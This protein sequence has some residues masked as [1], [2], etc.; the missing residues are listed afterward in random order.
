MRKRVLSGRCFIGAQKTLALFLICLFVF[1]DI[2]TFLDWPLLFE[3]EAAQATIDAT[4]STAQLEHV[5]IGSQTVFVSDQVGYKF[6]VD[7]TG[8]CVYSK[9]TNG[10]TSWGAAVTVDAVTTCFGVAVWYDRWTPGDNGNYIHIL[11]MD[12]GAGADELWYNRLDT[13]SDTR[14]LGQTPTS[15]VSNSGQVPTY[16]AG[17]NTGSIT[18][19]TDGTLYMA[20]AD[21]SDSFVVECSS[22]CGVATSWTETGTNPMDLAAD[23]SLVL[24]LSGGDI[25]LINRDISA[26]DMRSKVWNNAGSSWSASWSTI[27]ANALENSVYDPAF[28]A[29]VNK[30]TGDVFLAYVDDST[31]GTIGGNNDSIK[32]ALY[33]GGSWSSK[34][35]VETNSSL[36]LTDVSLAIDAN[37]GNVYVS[38]TGRTTPAT[39]TTA[40]V[41]W[42]TSTS[43]MTSWSSRQG[44][45]NTGADDI[46]GLG[47]NGYSDERMYVTWYGLTP[48][49]IFGNTLA[50]ITPITVVSASGTQISTVR[51][52]TTNFY[53]G[54]KFL[55]KENV[56]SRNVTDIT[57]AE[58]G[59]VDAAN[60]LTNITLRYDLDTTAPYDCAS[61]SYAGSES[62]FGSTDTNGFSG[63]DGSSSFTGSVGISPTQAMCVYV[64]M[65]VLKA[66][67]DTST[68]DI[69][70]TNPVT[71]VLLSGGVS[72][73]PATVQ[74][75]GGSTTIVDSNLTQTHYHWRNDNGN[76]TTATSRTA[77]VQD[78][79][80]NSLQQSVPVRLRFGV[81]NEGSTTS[82]PTTFRLEYANNPS[83][84]DLATGWTDVGAADDDWNMYDSSFVTHAANTTDISVGIGGV[85]N[86]NTDLLTPNGGQRDTSSQSGS[87]TFL[88][89]NWTELEFSI[90]ASTTAA[91]G[92]NYCFRLTNAGDPLPTYTNYARG[93]IQ[94]DVTVRAT[95]TQVA[96]VDIPTS[97]FYIG[98]TFS[99]TENTSS[100]NVTVITI[101]ESGSVDAT[102]GLDGVRLYY[103]LDTTAPYNCVSETYSGSESQFGATTTFSGPDGTV[104][105]SGSQSIS[106][107]STM[108]VYVVLDVTEG[109]RNGETIDIS[110]S[111]G[112]NVT[113]SGGGSVAPSIP[114]DI[115][116]STTIAGA[117]VTQTHYHWRNDD[118]SESGATSATGGLQDTTVTDFAKS[119]P[120]RLRIGISNEGSTTSVPRRYTL[121]YGIKA[122]T[123]EDVSV[124]SDADGGG[125]SWEM[126]D[127][128]NLSNGSDTT[129]IAEA[130]GGVSDPGGKTFLVSN[131][132]VRDTESLSATTTLTSTQYTDLEYSI[133]STGSTPYET[134]FC[135]RV[136]QNGTPL[137]QYDQYAELTTT[138]KRDF[139]IQHGTSSVTG[140]GVT[141]TA[142]V[143]YIAP[144][145]SSSAFV[146]I[147]NMFSTGAG[148][149]AAGN[150]QNGDDVTAYITNPG[151]IT[152]NFTISRASTAINNTQVA[153]E[154]IEYIGAPGG[155]N[156]IIVRDQSE[157]SFTGT[158]AVATGTAVSNVNDDTDIVPFITGI[159][160]RSTVATQYYAA[161]A[162]SKWNSATDEPVF[163][164]IGTGPIVDVS[165]AVVEF[166]GLNWKIQ[167]AEHSYLDPTVVESEE[168]SPVISQT[169]AFLH[170]QK[171]TGAVTQ[172]VHFGHEVWLPSMGSVSFQVEST[173]ATTS[174]LV[175]VAW[176]IENTQ[177]ANGAMVVHQ[178]NGLIVAGTEPRLT[179]VTLGT[180]VE[181][182]NNSSVFSMSRINENTTNYPR[183]LGSV[184]L[185]STS[186]YEIWNSDRLAA[187]NYR[188]RTEVVEWP[189]AD[190]AIRQNY[191][192]FYV[193]NDALLPTDAWPPGATDLGENTPIASLDEPLADGDRVRI[194]MTARV[195]NASLP[196][197]LLTVKLQYGVRVTTCS[198]INTWS[199]AGG[200]GSGAIWRGYDTS[201]TDGLS[202]SGNPPTGGD[203]LISVADV[204][205][206]IVEENPAVANEFPVSDGDDIEYD[207]VV[208]QNGAAQKTTYC[209]RMIKTDD[210]N[211]DGYFNYPQLR[212]EG[213]T[214]ATQNWRWYDDEIN[215]T[216]LIALANENSAPIDVKKG[217]TIKL[218]VTVNE[219]KNLSQVNARFKLQFSESPI[220]ANPQD[221]VATTT[222]VSDSIWCYADGAS[223]D[224]ATITTKLLTDSDSCGGGVGNGCGVHNE[225]PD[226]RNGFTH[227]ASRAIENEFTIQYTQVERKFGRVYYF[228]LYDLVNDLPVPV[229]TSYS[230]PSVVGESSSLTFTLSGIA[231]STA[232][233]GV[234]TDIATTP[235]SVQYGAL[236]VGTELEAAQQI[237]V[238]TN[239]TDGYAIYL[240]ANQDLLDSSGTLI[241]AIA[242]TN[243]SPDSW[244]TACTILQTGCFGYHTGDDSLSG[245]STR[246]AP[247]NT[248]AAFSTTTPEE[249][250]FSS[251]P[252]V[253]E[254]TDI[255]Y[256]IQVSESQPAGLY[257]NELT[258]LAI[259]IF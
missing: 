218:R 55:I 165:Y 29:M 200:I 109:A 104:S 204:S 166:T 31:T 59:T 209:F 217:N 106:T 221:V 34:T 174:G 229:N 153:W 176:I 144:S 178:S 162:T 23:F 182:V 115:T 145:S 3:A 91:E 51:A 249:I 192:R 2:H 234:T 74:A 20:S 136:T 160:S 188:Y 22:N 180:P 250:M 123:C 82:L 53:V 64:V 37:N 159:R 161:Q 219:L 49:D 149:S 169:Q 95:S 83:T 103:D 194:R 71:D 126:Y 140:T 155:D 206:R 18:K 76:E 7:S 81:S 172:Q 66:A 163:E 213:Y 1:S 227:G 128:G 216:P 220:F 257:E 240:F 84:C 226:I 4:V 26:D 15:A 135:F 5:Y 116:G 77:G 212:T 88:P 92:S 11:T 28:S 17:A 13:T 70:I 85:D 47:L 189:A 33:S 230:Y 139:K 184:I 121:E 78:T 35:N 141:L 224:N 94:A 10:G 195:A 245:G 39:A 43:A 183:I 69:E 148:N 90:V 67:A 177:T 25:L 215:E 181:A 8:T 87:L 186:T 138:V 259:P 142:G 38:Y 24:P 19:G 258:F 179:V 223:N 107:T 86:E 244:E 112:S 171:R 150:T 158:G 54:G 93:T 124:W 99:I 6:Y 167:R 75:I 56:T 12:A 196:A 214:P 114:I 97:N 80:L 247:D 173:A 248:Y 36:G 201:V 30:E 63:A 146:R 175:S 120:I 134:T 211:L 60:G 242:S 241:P 202:L 58:T 113:V 151:N 21:A 118:G 208:E 46:Y 237:S 68:L 152:T 243:Q 185:T 105:F 170:T 32:T 154:I 14:L 233:E 246:F 125:I 133:A 191:Y 143:D 57:I 131:G 254:S 197:G 253:S 228:R 193:D 147:T 119:T 235:T 101:N 205:G 210:T 41:Y 98:G 222:C 203:L 73:V 157:V 199:D 207:W 122:T 251:Q 102:V 48:D 16:A 256:K 44:P 111:S 129:D 231:S 156:E 96:S 137:L 89:T 45:V 130:N 164:R 168:I 239:A 72:A 52:S 40:N 100:R 238:I 190:L 255:I 108:C 9:T 42:A 50:D 65:D 198:A 62:Q 132:G 232:T 127:S 110:I 117:V 225:S 236:N 252:T 187:S 79:A 61:E 27:D